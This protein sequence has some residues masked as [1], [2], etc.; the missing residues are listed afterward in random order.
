MKLNDIKKEIEAKSAA[1]EETKKAYEAKILKLKEDADAAANAASAASASEDDAAYIKAM[2]DKRA[3]LDLIALYSGKLKDKKGC[4]TE[5][6]IKSEA[7]KIKAA[8]DAE[9][10]AF[11]PGIIKSVRTLYESVDSFSGKIEE[12]NRLWGLVN[13][14]NGKATPYTLV[15]AFKNYSLRNELNR[16]MLMLENIE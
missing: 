13:E 1:M 4:M 10:A 16:V 8:I 12:A 9:K 5:A 6:E 3:A 7:E 2:S 11:Y 14:I 15:D